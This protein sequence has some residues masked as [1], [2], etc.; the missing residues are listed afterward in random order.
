MPPVMAV[1]TRST[2]VATSIDVIERFTVRSLA[3]ALD[4]R[5]DHA[6]GFAR[7]V[8]FGRPQEP[9]YTPA[10]GGSPRSHRPCHRFGPAET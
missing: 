4:R 9:V 6:R 7:R 2:N 10:A 5:Q 8:P 3:G 1:L